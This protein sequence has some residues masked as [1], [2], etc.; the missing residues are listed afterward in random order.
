MASSMPPD[1]E[2][3][4]RRAGFVREHSLLCFFLLTFGLSWAGMLAAVLLSPGGLRP[5][6]SSSRSH[7]GWPSSGCSWD[8]W[9]QDW[10]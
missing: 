10:S 2:D 7:S 8:P 4:R 5:H 1:V 9:S 3:E 6:P